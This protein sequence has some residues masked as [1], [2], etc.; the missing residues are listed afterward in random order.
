MAYIGMRSQSPPACFTVTP[1]L[2]IGL[3]RST[4][5]GFQVS[6][7]FQKSALNDHKI[8]STCWDQSYD[9]YPLYIPFRNTWG[10]ECGP[11]PSVGSSFPVTSRC[12]FKKVH[13]M[14]VAKNKNYPSHLCLRTSNVHRLWPISQ[15]MMRYSMFYDFQLTSILTLQSGVFSICSGQLPRKVMPSIFYQVNWGN[16]SL[17]QFGKRQRDNGSLFFFFCFCKASSRAKQVNMY[18]KTIF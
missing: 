18:L 17:F 6:G 4:V 12:L 14:R 16:C 11:L 13:L 8:P 5:S 1:K 9:S 3:F 2:K 7:S 15:R 10:F